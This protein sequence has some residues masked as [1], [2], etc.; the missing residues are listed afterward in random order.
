MEYKEAFLAREMDF[1]LQLKKRMDEYNS[2]FEG[3]VRRSAE[4]EEDDRIRAEQEIQNWEILERF[5][6]I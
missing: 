3:A 2:D 5:G 6:M 1:F 4:I